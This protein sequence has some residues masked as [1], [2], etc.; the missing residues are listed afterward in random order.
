MGTGF[1]LANWGGKS[2]NPA[3]E[4]HFFMFW[5]RAEETKRCFPAKERAGFGAAQDKRK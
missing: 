1:W 2:K 3:I 5:V 4:T